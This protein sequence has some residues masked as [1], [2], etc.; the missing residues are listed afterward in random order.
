MRFTRRVVIHALG[1]ILIV[2]GIVGLFLPFL[3]GVL[4][5]L[6]GLY[7]VSFESRP[8]RR[9]LLFAAGKHPKAAKA[10]GVVDSRVRSFLGID[11]DRG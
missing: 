9:A 11:H 7:L 5:I 10:F 6:V 8:I 2:G 4:F 1:W 3:Q